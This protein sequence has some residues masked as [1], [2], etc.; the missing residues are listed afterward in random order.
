M[1]QDGGGAITCLSNLSSSCRSL[2]LTDRR[3]FPTI[4]LS[5][6]FLPRLC[7][8]PSCPVCSRLVHTSNKEGGRGEVIPE[9]RLSSSDI[10]LCLSPSLTF[11]CD[12][13]VHRYSINSSMIKMMTFTA[14]WSIC[15]LLQYIQCNNRISP[16]SSSSS[17]QLMFVEY[18]DSSTQ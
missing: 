18:I 5:F 1:S 3:H 8:P 4:H 11:S 9:P 16:P 12:T 6:S 10:I 14:L 17:S 15:L 7:P 13:C 2:S